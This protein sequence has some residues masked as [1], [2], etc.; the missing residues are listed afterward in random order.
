MIK[1]NNSSSDDT[2]D[3]DY[4]TKEMDLN[5]ALTMPRRKKLNGT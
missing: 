5:T 3:P 4:Y 2:F 1:K